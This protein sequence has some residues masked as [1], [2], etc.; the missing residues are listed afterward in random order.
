LVG[1]VGL[2]EL[3]TRTLPLAFPR[4]AVLILLF[5]A[6]IRNDPAFVR[7]LNI[8]FTNPSYPVAP[9]GGDPASEHLVSACSR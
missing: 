5:I 6:V 1:W 8:R 4:W 2:Y 3:V 7:Y 9:A